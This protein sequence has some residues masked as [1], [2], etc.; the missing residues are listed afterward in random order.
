MASYSFKTQAGF[1]IDVEG[2]SPENALKNILKLGMYKYPHLES[3]YLTP[4][5]IK[6]DK[7]G[8]SDLTFVSTQGTK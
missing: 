4:Y 3:H 6:Y 2:N 7:N 8:V 1:R 5:F